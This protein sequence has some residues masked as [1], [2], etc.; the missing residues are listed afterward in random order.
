[1]GTDLPPTEQRLLVVT[2]IHR[3]AEYLDR[4][5]RGVAEQHRRP[6]QWVVVD[7]GST[8]GSGEIARRWAKNLPFMT[9]VD[10]P[11]GS[12]PNAR[13]GLA[14]AR[15]AR[16]FNH[17]LAVADWRRFTHVCKLDGDIELPPHW[18]AEL[19]ARFAA[20]S[21]FGIGGGRLTEPSPSGMHVIPIPA[22]HV[23]GAVKLYRRECLE[24][25]GGIPER[26]AW[27]TI[28]ETYARM[29]G[30]R[31]QS[32]QQLVAIHHRPWGSADG[33][34]RGR[35]RHGEC[36]WIIH[37]SLP[38]VLL[39]SVKVAKVPPAGLSG[40]AFVFGYARS[41]A[42]H[43]PRVEDPLFRRYVRCE[44]RRR[45]RDAVIRR[46]SP[47]RTSQARPIDPLLPRA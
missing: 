26:L 31:T 40:A 3:E 43:T 32:L 46:L 7:D 14:I 9:V 23:H 11:Q 36:A 30:Y 13:D 44:L 28:D 47:R 8:D 45:L 34:L 42:R 35:A 1:M 2:P 20:D 37:Q 5:A 38:W 12:L 33:R 24:A 4:V 22:Y 25:I 10:V 17:G 39:R 27:D 16:A 19:L 18:F 21:Q 29:R 15:D 6:D 41:A